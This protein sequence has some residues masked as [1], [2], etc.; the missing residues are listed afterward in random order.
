MSIFIKR[1]SSGFILS[2][3]TYSRLA[4]RK[5]AERMERGLACIAVSPRRLKGVRAHYVGKRL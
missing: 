3:I 2:D 1:D 5:K 4:S